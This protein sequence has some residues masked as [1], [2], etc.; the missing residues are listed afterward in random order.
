MKLL[1]TCFAIAISTTALAAD[2]K[3]CAVLTEADLH[4]VLGAQWKRNEAFSSGEYCAYQGAATEVVT[5][6]LTRDASMGAAAIL[7][8]RQ[9]LAGSKAKPAAGP[10]AGAYRISTPAATKDSAVLDK[11]AKTIYDRLP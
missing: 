5:L 11:L 6:I 9:K 2:P 1:A 3:P 7:A 10:G 8:G 4:A